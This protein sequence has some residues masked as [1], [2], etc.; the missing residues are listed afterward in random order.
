MIIDQE[1]FHQL[2]NWIQ[3]QDGKTFNIDEMTEDYEKFVFHLKFYINNRTPDDAVLE[4]NSLTE[5]EEMYGVKYT[6]FRVLEF[7]EGKVSDNQRIK[8]MAS[9][10]VMQKQERMEHLAQKSAP[11]QEANKEIV[12]K[13]LKTPGLFQ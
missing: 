2:K 13:N 10:D 11:I 3:L 9:V 4:F 8:L 7:F 12:K 1:Y 5:T 6:Q